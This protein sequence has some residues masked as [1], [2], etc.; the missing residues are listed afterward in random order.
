MLPQNL[1]LN[2]PQENPQD[3]P[4]QEAP[5]QN[6][7]IPPAAPDPMVQLTEAIAALTVVSTMQLANTVSG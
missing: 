3:V 7:H 4:I 1:P 6:N 2:L 5:P